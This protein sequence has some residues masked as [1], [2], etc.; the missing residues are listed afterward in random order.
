VF[1]K[2]AKDL[3]TAG[4]SYTYLYFDIEECPP[5]QCWYSDPVANSEF[6]GAAVAGAQAAG[7]SVGIYANWN[8]WPQLMGSNS[9]FSNLPLW[10]AHWDGVQGF[11]DFIPF[12]GWTYPHMKQYGDKS[13]VGCYSL[14]DV[15]YANF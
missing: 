1:N 8:T 9:S 7:A 3:K 6:L 15:N 12:N 14:V 11:S 4:V 13:D 5:Q 2:L 10:Y